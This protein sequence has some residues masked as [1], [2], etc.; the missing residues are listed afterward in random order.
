[1]EAE[2]KGKDA[3]FEE[4][5]ARAEESFAEILMKIRATT[6]EKK[7]LKVFCQ[8]YETGLQVFGHWSLTEEH[9][10]TDLDLEP[11]CEALKKL[12]SKRQIKLKEF[13]LTI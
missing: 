8:N 1:M 2:L 10:A 12:L 11:R 5:W 3:K 6:D 7:A 9:N 4:D 13:R